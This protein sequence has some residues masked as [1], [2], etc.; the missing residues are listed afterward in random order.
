MVRATPSFTN[1]LL[2]GMAGGIAGAAARTAS[3]MAPALVTRSSDDDYNI[4][5]YTRIDLYDRYN[6]DSKKLFI[7]PCLKM[8]ITNKDM[9]RMNKIGWAKTYD[10]F[11]SSQIYNS[12]VF[13]SN[14]R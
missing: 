11:G 3:P 7:I 1:S 10:V 12:S 9:E 8:K 5:Y 14:K 6:W 2:S 13:I 4:N